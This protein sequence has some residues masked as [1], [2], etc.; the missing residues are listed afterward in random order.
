MIDFFAGAVTCGFVIAGIF[1]LRFW[2]QTR[3]RLLLSFAGAFWLFA[4]NQFAVSWLGA[5][6]ERTNYV[7]LLRVL[8]F[9]LI[10]L[11]IVGKNLGAV[12]KRQ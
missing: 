6:D 7:Y 9:V 10:L 11:A 5:D 1:F 8:A 3:D 2:K 4:L 12:G